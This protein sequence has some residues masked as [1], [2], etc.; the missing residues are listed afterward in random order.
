MTRSTEYPDVL[1]RQA[2]AAAVT[3]LRQEAASLQLKGEAIDPHQLVN[4]ETYLLNLF[5][6]AASRQ[7]TVSEIDNSRFRSHENAPLARAFNYGAAAG[8]NILDSTRPKT[9]PGSH[10]RSF[11]ANGPA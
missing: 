6:Y 8:L 7:D 1:R 9:V 11:R 4:A 3:T 10:G 2:A 5:T